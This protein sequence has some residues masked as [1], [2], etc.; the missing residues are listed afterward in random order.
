[1][2]NTLNAIDILNRTNDYSWTQ[3]AK[4]LELILVSPFSKGLTSGGSRGFQSACFWLGTDEE[5]PEEG[6]S[7]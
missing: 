4:E 5:V 3:S 6:Q 2:V 1:M 7:S